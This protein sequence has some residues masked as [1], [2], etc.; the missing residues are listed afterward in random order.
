MYIHVDSN[1]QLSLKKK[2]LY[3]GTNS[4]VRLAGCFSNVRMG[5]MLCF[6]RNCGGRCASVAFVGLRQGSVTKLGKQKPP[7]SSE[8]GWVDYCS[9]N[10]ATR[11]LVEG[12]S[13]KVIIKP[14]KSRVA[15]VFRLG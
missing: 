2:S 11:F 5:E 10:L 7:Q 13:R 6:G 12:E 15:L 8:K 4:Y 1:L 9:R 14:F 3:I